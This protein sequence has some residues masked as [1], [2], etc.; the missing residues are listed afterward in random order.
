MLAAAYTASGFAAA[1]VYA[2][3]MLRGR[4]GPYE[5]RGLALGMTLV[6]FWI[7]PL[8]VAGDL[9]GRLLRENQP[10]KLAALE[11]LEHTRKG[12]PLTIGG[13]VGKDGGV[14][15]GI[16]IPY[17]LSLL[18]A[19]DPSATI[20][21][22]DAFPKRNRPNVPVVRNAFQ[23]MV[24]IGTLLGLVTIA[25]WFARWRRP[26]W[27]RGRRLL[28]GL[29]AAGPLSFACIEAGW[30][31]TEVGRQPWIIYGFR[32]VSES[33]TGSALVGLMF[34]LFTLLY[35]A[36]SVVTVV[37]LRSELALLPR[38]AQQAA[39]TEPSS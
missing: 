27:L 38:R 35:V 20:T 3:A 37:A 16:E 23:F 34:V 1:A 19:R 21:G 9:A 6:A 13:L 7:I 29:V 2:F 39:T 4:R 25:Y 15:Y 8:G 11:G 5:R 31:V 12:A 10:A 22:L 14:R 33:L 30:I 26:A 36:L 18:A 32:R 28:W 17:G 24:G